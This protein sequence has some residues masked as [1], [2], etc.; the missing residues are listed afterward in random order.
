MTC[1][2]LVYFLNCRPR[3]HCGGGPCPAYDR[4]APSCHIP[5]YAF[6]QV[7]LRWNLD[8]GVAVLPKTVTPSRARENAGALGWRLAA[9][10]GAALSELTRGVRYVPVKPAHLAGGDAAAAVFWD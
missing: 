10:D 3:W 1:R 5:D 4:R 9:A 8:R 2:A 7:L 6:R